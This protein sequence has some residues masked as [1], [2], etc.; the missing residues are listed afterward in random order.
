MNIQLPFQCRR[1]KSKVY[2]DITK[3]TLPVKGC[4]LRVW[5]NGQSL[6]LLNVKK[7][8]SCWMG[9]TC[10]CLLGE[11]KVRR[12]I[13]SHWL[14]VKKWP[15]SII[16]EV[17]QETYKVRRGWRAGSFCVWMSLVFCPSK[18]QFNDWRP[19][20]HFQRRPLSLSPSFF[21]ILCH[22]RFPLSALSPTPL[23]N[24]LKQNVTIMPCSSPLQ[25]FIN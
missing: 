18:C 19:N 8:K 1:Q 3:Q 2:C 16:V 10:I 15:H 21:L 4:V 25:L 7:K 24:W 9:N 20:V 13:R 17:W 11:G 23:G 6:W 5:L 14:H 12:S 22:C